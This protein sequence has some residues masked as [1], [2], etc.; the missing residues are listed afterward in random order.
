[1]S[2]ATVSDYNLLPVADGSRLALIVGN[3]AYAHMNPLANP[4]NDATDMQRL[5]EQVGFTTTLVLDSSLAEIEAATRSFID[6]SKSGAVTSALFF[7]AG[8]AVQYEGSN[9]LIPVDANITREYEL[10]S[11]AYQMDSLLKGLERSSA[12]LNL[13]VLDACRDN[14]F[15]TTRGG[16]RGLS[17]MSLSSSESMV[18]FATA[19]GRVAEDGAGENSPFTLAMKEHL[20]TPDLEIR[21][22]IAR[23]SRSVQEQTGGRQVPWV[24]TSFTGQFFFLTG[25]QELLLRE[26]QLQTLSGEL[27]TLEVELQQKME[28]IDQA[29]SAEEIHRLEIE[30]RLLEGQATAKRLEEERIIFLQRAAEAQLAVLAQERAAKEQLQSQLSEEGR[31][32]E[33]LAQQRRTELA[34]LAQQQSQALEVEERL[35]TIEAYLAAIDEMRFS[36]TETLRLTEA[37]FQNIKHQQEAAYRAADPQDPWETPEGFERRVR[38]FT[39]SLEA[40][41]QQQL[42]LIESQ[43]NAELSQ[44]EHQLNTYKAALLRT[45][46]EIGPEQLTVRVLPFDAYSRY[47]PIEVSSE[48]RLM[49]FVIPIQYRIAETE[50]EAI[51][52][53]YVRIDDAAKANALIATIDYSLEELSPAFWRIVP[54]RLHLFTLL[55][56]EKGQPKELLSTELN[57]TASALPKLRVGNEYEIGDAGPA[58]G[59]IFYDKG[60]YSDGWRY[61]EAAPAGW[62]GTLEDPHHEFGGYGTLIGGTSTAIG[63][64]KA[65]TEKIVQRLGS[66]SYAARIAVNYV[67]TVGGVRYD[68][69]FLPSKDELNLLYQNL[70]KKGLAGFSVDFYWSSSEVSGG[71]AWRQVFRGNYQNNDYRDGVNRVRPIRAF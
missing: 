37:E 66:G 14:P 8:H 13:I 68:D 54:S 16:D 60:S 62:S 21:H 47:F 36:Y 51:G 38:Q 33:A 61:L 46:F 20:L 15:S 49:P 26:L 32:L 63:S 52:R 65:N 27:A 29:Q 17:A 24:N 45:T 19:P 39:A 5:L 6:S 58:G 28:A 10:I 9:Y 41:Q 23:I 1:M 48:S 4:V 42:S 44:L 3:S 64:G 25:E 30:Q 55:E 69:W 50:R 70:H 31:A 59:Y 34:Q 40:E 22:L 18:V 53:E 35:A 11:K 43:R 57:I 7:Y 71:Y 12:D 2:N 67:K 56:E